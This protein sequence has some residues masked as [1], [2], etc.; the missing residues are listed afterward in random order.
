MVANDPFKIRAF[1]QWVDTANY[2]V[3]GAPD[4]TN[5]VA[6]GESFAVVNGPASRNMCVTADGTYDIYFNPTELKCLIVA[7]GETPN[8]GG[9]TPEQPETKPVYGLVGQHNA[10]GGSADTP[11]VEYAAKAGYFKATQALV[12][13]DPFKIRA[14]GEWVDTAN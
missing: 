7:A 1:G 4:S 13:K 10:W 14:Y 3:D 8:F 12:A 5:P 2:G 6:V 9:T 11:F